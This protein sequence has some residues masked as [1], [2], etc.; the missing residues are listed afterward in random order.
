MKNSIHNDQ[1]SKAHIIYAHP[2][3][4]SFNHAIL[5][6]ITEVLKK[7]SVETTV[8]DLYKINFNPVLSTIDIQS[9]KNGELAN[10]VKIEQEKVSKADW[11]FVVYPVWWTQMPAILKGYIDRVFSPKFAF[12]YGENGL[13]KLLKGR[14]AAIFSTFG[15]PDKYYQEEG[16]LKAFEKTVD[17]GIF[18]YTGIEVKKHFHFGSI[19]Y[20]S[21]DDRK[22]L[23]NTTG[24]WIESKLFNQKN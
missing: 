23:L 19:P 7:A 8:S 16:F 6:R 18:E 21:D 1:V 2:N 4:N 3:E 22:D 24:Q 9:R 15:H 11:I 20:I 10:D 14:K 5:K 13:I 17:E 12:D